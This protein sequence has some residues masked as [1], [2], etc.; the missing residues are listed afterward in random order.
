MY[1]ELPLTHCS[2]CGSEDSEIV[3][4]RNFQAIRCRKCK[5]E[6]ITHAFQASVQDSANEAFKATDRNEF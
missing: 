2:K 4:T 3:T 6:K 5:H 1:V